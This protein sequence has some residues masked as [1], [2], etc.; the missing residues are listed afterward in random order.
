MSIKASI[1]SRNVFT[2]SGVHNR[3]DIECSQHMAGSVGLRWAAV[4][5]SGHIFACGPLNAGDIE[6]SSCTAPS[7][8]SPSSP[9]SVM[10][11]P[12]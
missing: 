7:R 11:S 1:T 2:V 10:P 6:L 12:V 8:S 4:L 3:K 9:K 5:T